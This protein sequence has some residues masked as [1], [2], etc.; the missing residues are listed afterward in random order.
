VK[1]TFLFAL[2]Y[3]IGFHLNAQL[4]VSPSGLMCDLLREPSEAVIT[5]STPEFSW[6]FPPGGNNQK[7]YRILVASSPFLIQEGIA[8]LWDSKLV[9]DSKSVNIPYGGKSLR[10]NSVYWW[11]V[12]V[13]AENGLESSY[14]LPQRF[15][16]GNFDRSDLDY[17]GQSRWIELSE[18][19][20]VSEDKQCASLEYIDPVLI[21]KKEDGSF[22]IAFE[23]SVIGTLAFFANAS[24]STSVSIYLGERNSENM[25]VHKNPGRSNIGFEKVDM[26]LKQG[27]HYY[28][29][30]LKEKNPHGY[31]HSQK[32][33]PHYPEVMPFR[34]VE[35]TGGKG[36]IEIMEAKQAALFYYFDDAAADFNCSDTNL[37]KVWD[38]CKYTQKATPFLGVYCDGNRERMPYEADAYIQMLSH[39]ATDREY[40]IA[41]YTINFLLDHASWPTEWQMHMVLMAWE[42][43][44][45]SGDV[46]LLIDR[47]EDLKRKSLIGL[48]DD[49]GL[50][51]TRTGKKTEAFLRSLNFPGHVG[52]FR[53]IVD[54]P[55]GPAKNQQP[56]DYMSPLEGGETD[57]FVFTDYNAVVNAFHNRCLVLMTE[58][59]ILVGEKEDAAFFRDRAEEH[60]ELFNEAFLDPVKGIYTDGIETDHSSL[61]ANMFP[62]AFNLVPDEYVESVSAF[63][64]S[65]GMA[66]S[67]YGSQYLLEAL[68]NSGEADHALQLMTSDSKRS[69]LNMLRVG[70]TMTTEAWDE[71]FKPNLTWNHAWGSSPANIIARKLMGV[72]PLKPTFSR[73]RIAPQPGSLEEVKIRVPTIRGPIE[74][75]LVCDEA[76]WKMEISVP[77]NTEAELW[78]PAGFEKVLINGDRVQSDRVENFA[79]ET[80]KVYRVP[81]GL[82][83]IRLIR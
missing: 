28:M 23:K 21:E 4:L 40:S 83:T 50:I 80:R 59:A 9:S 47:Y 32:L 56:G 30:K 45:H 24:E 72:E 42:Y 68:Y 63:I 43:Y 49:S 70:S 54:W 48:T 38:L 75:H 13:V 73:I 74:S 39:F 55:Q 35:I 27:S 65:R 61:H 64:K 76:E 71:Y 22:Y 78:L 66:C 8:D 19:H 3:Y 11:A 14:S 25:T 2:I 77:G 20:W 15:N 60:R 6:I 16:T 1:K 51:S 57:G 33:A 53:D 52:Q 81:S 17:P 31:L 79:R 69:W 82:F 29:V 37:L 41:R 58:I 67:V 34:Y 44:M 62:M 7:A 26:E 5:D 12:K 36:S 10:K 46:N 18:N